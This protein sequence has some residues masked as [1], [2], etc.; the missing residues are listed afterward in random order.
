MTS[1][2]HRLDRPWATVEPAIAAVLR[3]GLQ[4]VIEDVIVAVAR[5][6]PAYARDEDARVSVA[7]QQGVRV[8]LERLMDLL[9]H[10]DAPLGPATAV[11]QQIGAAEYRA[12][13][14]LQAVL[15]AY[16]VG[17]L[18][19]WRGLS[20]ISTQAGIDAVQTARLAEACFAYIDEISAVSAAGYAAAQSADAGRREALRTAL[21]A[22]LIDPAG[23]GR[24]GADAA[25]LG[26]QVPQ[27]VVVA[28]WSEGE[29]VEGQL[30][31]RFGD[32]TVAVLAD[33]QQ[34]L[35]RRLDRCSASVGTVEPVALAATSYEH[36]KALHRLR[37]AGVIDQHGLALAAHHLPALLLASDESITRAL[38]ADVLQPLAGL[39]DN[40]REIAVDTAASW[41]LNG[42]SRA[43]VAQQLHVHPQTVA[44]RMENVRSLFGAELATAEGR[45]RL[46][47]ALRAE[48]QLRPRH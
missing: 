41:L 31:A 20:A 33:D 10:D 5:E 23:Q 42:G 24:V 14:P 40:R 9:G 36:A 37:C 48:Q 39:D 30:A 26:W 2:H 34:M 11:Y 29:A 18:A 16:R 35:L 17:A 44:Y 47:L 8:A 38:I 6:V 43:A 46:L 12:G 21:V 19:T 28:V 25:Q 3:T 45:W 4:P 15:A 32:L 27:R 1:R 22:S 13:R 7:V